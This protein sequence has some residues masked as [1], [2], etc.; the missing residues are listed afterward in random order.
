MLC[1]R[2]YEVLL[3]KVQ[4]AREALFS[5][6]PDSVH[7]LVREVL[8]AGRKPY[9]HQARLA[10]VVL[11]D[12]Q[13]AVLVTPV[14]SGKTLAFLA[15]VLT[16]LAS[17][18]QATA[19]LIYPMNALALDQMK[20]LESLGFK[21]SPE[22]PSEILTLRA[23]GLEITVGVLTGDT[24]QAGRTAIRERAQILLTNPAALH[25]AVLTWATHHYVDGSSWSR[26]FRHLAIIVLDEA[27]SQNGV[28]GTHT[29]L[30]LRRVQAL[31]ESLQ[32]TLPAF[33]LA[34]ATIGNPIEH[35][36]ALTGVSNWALV[37]QSGAKCQE[38]TYQILGPTLSPDR[39]KWHPM[40][41]AKDLAIQEI[42]NGNRV[43]IFCQR[44]D[45]TERLA[46]RLNEAVG[47]GTCIHFHS[48]LPP[49]EKA[50]I[51]RDVLTGQVPAVASTSAL[52]LGVDIGG[53][54]SVIIVGH[55][56]D[57]ASFFQRGGRAGRTSPGRIFLILDEGGQPLN[58]YLSENPE[59]AFWEAEARTIFPMNPN[60]AKLHA[61][62]CYLETRESEAITRKWFPSVTQADLLQVLSAK[63]PAHERIKLN[64]VGNVGGK[65]TAVDEDGNRIQ[66]LGGTQALANWFPGAILR[67]ALGE[68][69]QIHRVDAQKHLALAQVLPPEEQALQIYTSP[70]ARTMATP[71]SVEGIELEGLG[72]NQLLKRAQGGEYQ[73]RIQTTGFRLFRYDPETE[74][75]ERSELPL[76]EEQRNPPVEFQTCGVEFLLHEEEVMRKALGMMPDEAIRALQ[77][78][79]KKSIP[80]IIQ[81]RP[82]DVVVNVNPI[83][84]DPTDEKETPTSYAFTLMDWAEGGM[85]WSPALLQRF[86]AWMDAGGQLLQKCRCERQGCPRCSTADMTPQQRSALALA[87]RQLL[88]RYQREA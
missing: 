9:T 82:E 23:E 73:V 42:R 38:R 56:G 84:I 37:N 32:G 57:N 79:L 44:R 21:H 54:D 45:A 77:D 34:S 67:N 19:I 71:L 86:P 7:P 69:Y 40:A 46:K 1:S 64:G 60:L 55:P 30:V 10:S 50:E 22:D 88:G 78:A 24:S 35:A 66:V 26:F 12:R 28:D 43:L 81:A 18:P 15:P 63:T 36:S 65:F 51:T 3:T 70:I 48:G 20:N 83:R 5:E 87:M 41:I 62:C 61:A 39:T 8:T 27:H 53:L 16:L 17:D 68:S 52:E 72:F 6:F 33:I 59:A 76:F 14:A 2:K 13:N 80:V 31:C 49:E 74:R 4:P 47:L 75:A 85:G 58:A 25:H 29:A 11:D